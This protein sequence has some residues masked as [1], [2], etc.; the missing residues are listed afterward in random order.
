MGGITTAFLL[1]GGNVAAEVQGGT[2][3]ETYTRGAN[4]IRR[5]SSTVMTTLQQ[6][7]LGGI[8]TIL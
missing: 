8:W 4:L 7:H 3:T 1:D 5:E 6:K 2:V